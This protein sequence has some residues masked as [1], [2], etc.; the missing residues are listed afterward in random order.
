MSSTTTQ[1]AGTSNL[2]LILRLLGLAWRYKTGSLCVV[3][4]QVL[5]LSLTLSGLGFVGLGL[6][7]LGHDIGVLDRAPAWPFG[8][9]PSE[10]WTTLSL[11]LLLAG[12]V[13][14]IALVRFVLEHIATVQKSMLVQRIIVDLRSEVYDKVQRLSF[15]FFSD[16]TSG[17]I[18]NRVTGDV[19]AVRRFIDGVVIELL[20]MALTLV[21]FLVYMLQIHALLTLACLATTPALWILTGLFSKRVKPAYRTNRELFDHSIAVLSENIQGVHVVK[22][23]WTQDQEIE[24]YKASNTKVLDQKEWIFKQVCL[25]VP[26]I[27]FVPNL[28]LVVLLGFGGYLYASGE[29][30]FG[31]GLIVFSRLLE[32]FS[33]QVGNIAQVANAMQQSLTGAQRVFEVIDEPV[34]INEPANALSLQRPQGRVVF[35]NVGFAYNP[36]TPDVLNDISLTAEPGKAIAVVG[37][38]GAGKS[39]LLSLIPRFYDPTRGRVT[40]DGHDLRQLDLDDLRRSIG[41]VF[42]ESFLFSTTIAE[43]IAFGHPEA[44]QQ[45][46][47]RAAEIA[48]AHHFINQLEDGYNMIL[49]E[50]G[51]NLSGG[52]R[53]RLAIARALLLDP[54]ILILDDPT[55]A[56]DPETEHEILDAMHHAMDGRTTFIVAHRLSTLKRADLVVVLER[57]T[58]VQCGTHEQLMAEDGHYYEAANLQLVDDES[59]HLLALHEENTP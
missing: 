54:A 17:S 6:D 45:Q 41:V 32:Q 5:L 7:V 19:Q 37:A 11:A 30:A 49:A 12:A 3:G 29:L 2:R 55:S 42:Q 56:I 51:G 46:I 34:E 20:L 35:E 57:G 38:T 53:Q 15:R 24:K 25:F 40:L 44:T 28:N 14:A 18:I 48:Q 33:A 16:N 21:F 22:G 58:I 26:L 52:Q 23:F 10:D 31:T 8:W 4:L 39:T 47:T 9:E 13:L 50:G 59:R 43:N 36:D 1:L 27:S